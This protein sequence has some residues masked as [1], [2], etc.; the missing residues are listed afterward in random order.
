MVLDSFVCLLLLFSVVL[1]APLLLFLHGLVCLFAF[2]VEGLVRVW[3]CGWGWLVGF[4]VG[5]FGNAG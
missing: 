3:G 5:W 1:L 4:L 2:V